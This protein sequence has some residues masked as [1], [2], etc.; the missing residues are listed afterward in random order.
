MEV[1]ELIKLLN[2]AYDTIEALNAEA[3]GY[4]AKLIELTG[5]DREI[6]EARKLKQEAN[7][8]LD[9]TKMLN[10]T[11]KNEKGAAKEIQESYR[12]KL[13]ELEEREE[14]IRNREDSMSA[15]TGD[16]KWKKKYREIDSQ[17]D[18]VRHC[19]WGSFFI[20]V[21]LVVLVG[22]LAY[23]IFLK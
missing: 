20:N 22:V 14:R 23:M 12:E 17:F 10:F 8:E 21:A 4:A 2:L 1:D 6:K 16:G 19:F 7:N 11:L 3:E 13:L 5:S 15:V 18:F 9:K